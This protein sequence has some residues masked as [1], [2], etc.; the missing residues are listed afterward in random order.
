MEREF[1]KGQELL[2]SKIHRNDSINELREKFIS[3]YS[4][5]MGWDRNQLTD[6]QMN[7]INSQKGFQCPGMICG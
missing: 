7:E 3:D 2:T 4:M 6:E 1:L 5:K